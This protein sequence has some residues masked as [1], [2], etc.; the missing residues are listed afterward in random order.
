LRAGARKRAWFELTVV[1]ICCG[2]MPAPIRVFYILIY[3]I[4]H[5]DTSEAHVGRSL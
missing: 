4:R 1:T 2:A 3:Y 5:H